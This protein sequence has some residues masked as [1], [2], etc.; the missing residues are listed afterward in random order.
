MKNAMLFPFV[1][2]VCKASGLNV[3]LRGQHKENVNKMKNFECKK[4][5]RAV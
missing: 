2:F 5:H 1:S 4:W 3:A